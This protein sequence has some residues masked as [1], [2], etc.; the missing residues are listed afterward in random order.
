MKRLRA[1]YVV[2]KTYRPKPFPSFYIAIA[3]HLPIPLF[4]APEL[5][6][7]SAPSRRLYS[8]LLRNRRRQQH[9]RAPISPVSPSTPRALISFSISGNRALIS[10]ICILQ[11]QVED[12]FGEIEEVNKF[13][14]QQVEDNFGEIEESTD[15]KKQTVF[16][17]QSADVWSTSSTAE[18]CRCFDFEKTNST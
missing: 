9:H 14:P 7:A 1:L 10:S 11:T 6:G 18:D 17:L 12:N 16:F 4:A 15:V 8:G 3:T 13:V 5:A 2:E